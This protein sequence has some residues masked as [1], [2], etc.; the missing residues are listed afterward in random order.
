MAMDNYG[1]L[2][3]AVADWLDRTDAS[4]LARI[5][6]FIRMAEG[7]IYRDLRVRDNEFIASYR[8][9]DNPK[10]PIALPQNFREIKLV[11]HNDYPL[12]RISDQAYQRKVSSHYSPPNVKEFCTQERDLYL[13]P[14][15]T[16]EFPPDTE[17]FLIQV[18]YYGTESLGSMTVW[19]TSTNPNSNPESA[20]DA[21]TYTERPD[22]TTTRMFLVNPDMY[23]FG[24]LS[25]A[26]IYLREESKSATARQVFQTALN[27]IKTESEGAEYSGSTTAV[28]N[29]Y[30]ERGFYN[31]HR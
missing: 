28:S 13:F 3:L 19:G 29:I 18:H 5:P 6:D 1:E 4:T 20:G 11:T 7:E 23:L 27:E 12:E 17:D 10:N 22:E 30:T 31:D 24:A 15:T 26:Y 8:L 14:W 16:E 2:K 25:Y 9:L 21:A